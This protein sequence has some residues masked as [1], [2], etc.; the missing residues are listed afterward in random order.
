MTWTPETTAELRRLWADG[1]SASEISR[2]MGWPSRCAVIGK[3]NRLKLPSRAAGGR[4]GVRKRR[5]ILP[6]HLVVKPV[7]RTSP[8]KRKPP[9][10]LPTLRS[11]EPIYAGPPVHLLDTGRSRC[12]WIIDRAGSPSVYC[13]G[14]PVKGGSSW[15][16]EHHARVFVTRAAKRRAVE[17]A[18]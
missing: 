1:L 18:E 16:V 7:P 10:P 9:K 15:C 12:K 11:A 13:C 17:A 14:A 5:R 3:A 8:R 6:D 4:T 2:V